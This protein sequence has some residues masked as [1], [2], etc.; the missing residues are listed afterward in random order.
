MSD[1]YSEF[2]NS[3]QY[4]HH[5]L[6]CWPKIYSCQI[7]P[8]KNFNNTI[9]KGIILKVFNLKKNKHFLKN[10]LK[11]AFDPRV[12]LSKFESVSLRF[13]ENSLNYRDSTR[14]KFKVQ[15]AT[16]LSNFSK[17][18]TYI[19]KEECRFLVVFLS[20]YQDFEEEEKK[21][22]RWSQSGKRGY[23]I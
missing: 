6:V 20:L 18:I 15:V 8:V 9:Y 11:L 13:S 17:V 21:E 16:N 5:R 3:R 12:K 10:I 7:L 23:F 1:P 22:A 4:P 2:K 14:F 19:Y